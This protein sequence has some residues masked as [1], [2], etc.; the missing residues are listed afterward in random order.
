MCPFS[1][2]RLKGVS[3]VIGISVISVFEFKTEIRKNKH[4][5][6]KVHFVATFLNNFLIVFV[7]AL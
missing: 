4:S 7:N 2:T 3:G 5:R 6:I 1:E